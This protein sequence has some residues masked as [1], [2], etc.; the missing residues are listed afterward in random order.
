MPGNRKNLDDQIADIPA[1]TSMGRLYSFNKL[2]TSRNI[3]LR[4]E[5]I[6]GIEETY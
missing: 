4:T 1:F 3:I 6:K 2:L 5:T